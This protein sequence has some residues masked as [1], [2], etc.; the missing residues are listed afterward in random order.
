M[1]KRLIRLPIG[2]KSFFL[3]GPR[4]TGKSTLVEE[5]LKERPHRTI[6]LLERDTFLRYKSRPE[7]LRQ[8]IEAMKMDQKPFIIFI[9]EVQKIPEIL[10]EVHLLLE[11]YK[12]K[13]LFVMT[14]SSARKLKRFSANLLAGRA[15]QF[16]LYPL[17][18]KELGSDFHLERVLSKGS[19]PPVVGESDEDA[20]QT[21]N[22]YTQTYLKEEI[23]DE[24]LARNIG[25]FSKFLELAADQSGS[26]VNYS[27]IAR[28]TQV[29]VKTIQG[30]YQILEDTLIAIRLPTYTRSARKRLVLHP[31]YYLFDLGVIQALT[32]RTTQP[33]RKGTHL[34][35]TLFEHFVILEILRLAS[36]AQKN[37]RFYYWR[38]SHGVEVDL[39]I[40]TPKELWAIEIKASEQVEASQLQGLRS[41]QE[42]YPKAKLI[43]VSTTPYA[44]LT[45]PF[46]VISWQEFLGPHYLNL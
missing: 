33:I 10:D 40:E 31:K 17:T 8:E 1:Y 7:R 5:L 36:Y 24:A 37:W 3:F 45:G 13:L 26:I 14:G 16:F 35:G 11:R 29:T 43:C 4:Q 18:Y 21:L 22:A 41:F 19:L 2:K 20:V 23:L 39:V 42:D 44:Y 28:E 25:A 32:G 12:G 38:T 15:W 6:N 27:N 46:K 34:Y 30:Y 9:D